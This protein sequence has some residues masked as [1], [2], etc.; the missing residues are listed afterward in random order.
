MPRPKGRDNAAYRRIRAD[1]LVRD[2][3]TCY[4]C[5]GEAN[6][7]D[8]LI[9]ISRGGEDSYENLAAICRPCN[10]KKSNKLSQNGLFLTQKAPPQS[11]VISDLSELSG[12]DPIPNDNK[13]DITEVQADQG[14]NV[15]APVGAVVG[16]PIPRIH[17][18]IREGDQSR[19]AEALQ[20]AEDIG[21]TLMPWQK[22]ALGEILKMDGER[23]QYRQLGLICGRQQGKTFLAALRILAGIYLFGE[24]DVI[25]M[26][27]NRKL[28]LITWR[29][30]DWLIRNTPRLKTE[31][32]ATYTTNGAERIMFKNGAQISV[33][34][35][36]P[37]GARGMSADFLFIDELRAIDQDTYDAAIYTTNAR[38][39]QV[40][41]V[42]NAGDKNS[43]VLNSLRERALSGA[44]PTLAWLEWSAHPS[45]DIM[46]VKGWVE[47]CP[48]LG[49]YL[50]LETLKHLAATNDPMAFRCEVLCQWLDNTASPFEA[51]AFD[52]CADESITLVEGGDLYFAFDKSHTQRHAVLVAGQKVGDFVHLFV[53]QE[54][55]AQNPLDEVKLA[56]DINAHV[57]KWRPRVT[58]YDRYMSQNTATYLAASGVAMADC[59][60]KS[61]V[62]AAHRFAQM[63]SARVLRHKKEA[64]LVDAVNNCSSK[65]SEHGWRL[66]RRRSSGEICAAIGAAMV[67]WHS[68]TP[69]SKPVIYV[70]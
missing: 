37:N 14:K 11:F 24:K 17:S 53:L 31:W 15:S 26:A 49:H 23:W 42:S 33:V 36:T 45:R 29:Q 18:V 70:A 4:V 55:N 2:N 10:L 43:T 22:N 58:L 50:E 62:E 64:T 34:A 52:E 60:G 21:I 20:F 51:G 40:L 3:R 46:D 5:Q 41:T 28:S 44:S 48:A 47:S 38:K 65:I 30:I 9:P 67:S 1:V 68:S 16:S 27:V 56:S 12:F 8:H 35:A 13:T 57:Q 69:Q 63:M 7:V 61:Q 54:W 32:Q 39:A 6:E 19:V 66:V 25:L 59:S